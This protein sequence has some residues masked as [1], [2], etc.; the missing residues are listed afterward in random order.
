MGS[1]MVT[2]EMGSHPPRKRGGG[3]EAESR[4]L[5]TEK[6]KGSTLEEDEAPSLRR[7]AGVCKRDGARDE[8]SG[9]EAA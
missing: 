3:M 9:S 6:Q 2:D 4:Q 5:G 7:L 1:V 8:F